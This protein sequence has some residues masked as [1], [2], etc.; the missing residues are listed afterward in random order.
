MRK[1]IRTG[2]MFRR[3]SSIWV[4]YSGWLSLTGTPKLTDIWYRVA[5]S[6]FLVSSRMN[7]RSS[8]LSLISVSRMM[9][10]SSWNVHAEGT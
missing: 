2:Y 9:S 8:Y 6:A 1:P 5:S 10:W 7:E 3:F 4:G